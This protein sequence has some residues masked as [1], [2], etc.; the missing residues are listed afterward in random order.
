M[1]V[2]DTL[3]GYGQ[4]TICSKGTFNVVAI[5]KVTGK[6]SVVQIINNSK[7]QRNSSGRKKAAIAKRN[8]CENTPTLHICQ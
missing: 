4:L 7:S 5:Q 2:K 8:E 6:C 3:T 1:K